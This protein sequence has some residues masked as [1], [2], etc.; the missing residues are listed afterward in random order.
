M[1]GREKCINFPPRKFPIIFW[2]RI[3]W[4]DNGYNLYQKWNMQSLHKEIPSS[5]FHFQKKSSNFGV[6][7]FETPLWLFDF[8]FFLIPIQF[9]IWIYSNLN[10]KSKI[11]LPTKNK[12]IIL[13]IRSTRT[14]E[15]KR[16]SYAIWMFCP[17]SMVSYLSKSNSLFICLCLIILLSI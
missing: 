16:I 11:C 1:I 12:K 5:N 13:F 4:F 17:F 9:Q 8:F 7:A 3:I 10:F 6:F 2:I 15:K 14:E